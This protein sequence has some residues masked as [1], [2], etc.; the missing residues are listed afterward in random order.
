VGELKKATRLRLQAANI[1]GAEI[2]DD[3]K[4]NACWRD[5][6]GMVLW[7]RHLIVE[8]F[9]T[10][11]FGFKHSGMQEFFAGLYLARLYDSV[12]DES[13]VAPRIWTAAWRWPL[14]FAAE[15]GGAT[16][17]EARDWV[18]GGAC[19]AALELAFE[20]ALEGAEGHEGRNEY[21]WH[22]LKA[23]HH[24]GGDLETRC[25]ARLHA[26]FRQL[27][28]TGELKEARE[29]VRLLPPGVLEAQAASWGL[30][31]ERV[32]QL[33]GSASAENWVECPPRELAKDPV[34]HKEWLAARSVPGEEETYWFWQ[35]SA[36]EVGFK[37]EKRRHARGVR[38][39]W[40]Q[41]TAVT[42]D[43]YSLFDRQYKETYAAEL[44]AKARAGDCPAIRVSWYDGVVYA[45]WVGGGCRLPTESEWEFA[46]RA[47]H[48]D[49]ADLFSL[50]RGG[51]TELRSGEVNFNGKHP[52][53]SPSQS[54]KSVSAAKPAPYYVEETLPV[55]WQ[56]ARQLDWVE[57]GGKVK[58]PAYEANEWGLWQMHGNVWEWC[59]D[60]YDKRAYENR[61]SWD[62]SGKVG[63]HLSL[64][65]GD[66]EWARLYTI[67]LLRVL[68]G[69]SWV[70][71]GVSLRCARRLGDNPD[72]RY[73]DVGLRLSWES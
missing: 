36:E 20:T 61:V 16:A 12:R 44:A 24:A 17:A 54:E 60:V 26:G 53:L 39:F 21:R 27:L 42:V 64:E 15:L 56:A 8:E 19:G 65:A 52:H 41:A 50:G 58:P 67:G 63:A 7:T 5:V 38:R 43:Q 62:L 46:C 30:P 34:R 10:Q 32:G 55:R 70:S 69:G 45:M 31:A 4:W 23:A 13:R 6:G 22:L 71:S 33:L 1:G 48:D 3:N 11:V 68:R 72:A 37:S 57:R 73:H 2:A 29:A 9:D 59:M 14:Q 35:G 25:R 28:A 51:R 47:G 18:E 40:L 66:A 49:T